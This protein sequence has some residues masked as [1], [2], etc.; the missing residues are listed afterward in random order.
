MS[1]SLAMWILGITLASGF[2]LLLGLLLWWMIRQSKQT[3]PQSQIN[4]AL[5]QQQIEALRTQISEAVLKSTELTNRQIA[6]VGAQVQRQMDSV[7]QSFQTTTGHINTRLDNASKVVQTVSHQLGSLSQATERIF[8]ATRNIST[9]E[10]ILKPPKLRGGMGEILLENVLRDILPSEDFYE[11]Q[12]KFKTGNSVDAVI[13]LKDGMIPID[14][15]FPLDNFR[16][17]AEAEK[18][19][20][21]LIFRKEFISNVKKHIDD[22]AR[23]YILPDEGTLNF[24][25]MYVPA[26][27]IYYEMIVREDSTSASEDIYSFAASKHV[28]PVSPNSIYP[29]LM[30][31]ALGF[32]GLK[33]EAQAKQI[34][35]QL[36]RVQM[37]LERFTR[38]F[39]LVGT[40]IENAQKKFSEAEK[41][42]GRVEGKIEALK[43]GSP[44]DVIE[45]DVLELRER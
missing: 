41:K 8:E 36:T 33:I 26:E 21:R 9:L 16:R 25:L 14:A 45:P 29:Y 7:Q 2:C 15:K 18:D 24:A 31:I 30:T 5:M 1:V 37:D 23:K 4:A 12:H 44:S 13:C 38:E 19:A 10:D 27:N 34:L 42:L 43:Q 22:I 35:G 17:M 40:H 6:D 28:F 3:T 11:F 20:D 39:Q 32:R